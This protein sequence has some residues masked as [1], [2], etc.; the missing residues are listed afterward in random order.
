ML[1]SECAEITLEG[2][3]LSVKLRLPNPQDHVQR[4]IQQSGTFY[5][6]PL[7][8]EINQRAGL[9]TIVDV[10]A[11]IGNHTLWFAGIMGRQV[12]AFEPNYVSYRELLKNVQLNGL[13]NSVWVRNEAVGAEPGFVRVV[14]N[15][16]ANSGMAYCVDAECGVPR[17][18]LDQVGL[19]DVAVIK[20]DVEGDQL[21]VLNGAKETIARCRPLIYAEVATLAEQFELRDWML[22]QNYKY[23]GKWGRTAVHG[24]CPEEKFT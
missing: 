24:Y 18:K 21:K 4:M 15:T 22:E 10:G 14:D 6:L 5:E 16:Q 8:E 23:L 20:I 2:H 1:S 3:G 11:H 9:G 19:L 7:L 13:E 17:I 12:T